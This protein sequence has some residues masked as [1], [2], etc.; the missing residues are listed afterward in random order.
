MGFVRASITYNITALKVFDIQ[1]TDET[2]IEALA[3]I[4]AMSSNASEFKLTLHKSSFNVQKMAE[5]F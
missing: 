2:N 4:L 3:D 1:I 5:H